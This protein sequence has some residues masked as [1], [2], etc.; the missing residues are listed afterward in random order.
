MEV[1]YNDNLTE[2]VDPLSKNDND[3]KYEKMRTNFLISRTVLN[4]EII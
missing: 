3:E 2:I 4:E 1:Q